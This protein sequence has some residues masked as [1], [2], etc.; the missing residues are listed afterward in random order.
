MLASECKGNRS[1]N[2][3]TCRSADRRVRAV[4]SDT[5]NPGEW[6]L[7]LVLKGLAFASTPPSPVSLAVTRSGRSWTGL[8]SACSASPTGK[9]LCKG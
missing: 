5:R 7:S 2:R 3:V 8:A 9:L 4:F 1:G 6:R